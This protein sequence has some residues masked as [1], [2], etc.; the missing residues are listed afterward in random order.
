MT[1]RTA[2]DMLDQLDLLD[3]SVLSVGY[4]RGWVVPNELSRFAMSV[5]AADESDYELA[6]VAALTSAETLAPAAVDR[7][8]TQ[9]S[10]RT[11]NTDDNALERW[12]LAKLLELQ[13]RDIDWDDKVTRLEELAVEFGYPSDMQG[14][15]RYSPGTS[16]PL[17]EM[18]SVI[19]TL[20]AKFGVD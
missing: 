11:P 4:R 18:A 6:A 1:T 15:S 3:W 2:F 5:I 9:L 12:R 10:R 17:N 16:D 20:Q 19:H 14:C 8:L 13:A 7:F